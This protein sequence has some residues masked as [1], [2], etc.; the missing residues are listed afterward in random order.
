MKL[1]WTQ[2][3][4]K[5]LEDSYEDK[6][7]KWCSDTLNI[8]IKKVREKAARLGL[9]IKTIWTVDNTKYLKENY[10]KY[11]PNVCASDLGLTWMQIYHKARSLN[12]RLSKEC[13]EQAI[14][15]RVAKADQTKFNN[16]EKAV[17][18]SVNK[19][20]IDSPNIAYLLG[21]IWGD[22]Y[23]HYH[24]KNALPT[25]RIEIA[26]EDSTNLLKLLDKESITYKTYWR[27]R[28]TN[29]RKTVTIYI[30]HLGLRSI[31]E[32]FNFKNKSTLSVGCVIDKIPNNVNQ[33]ILGL[34]DADGC[35]Y[36]KSDSTHGVFN[37]FSSYDY[38]WSGLSD[39]LNDFNIK[40][41]TYQRITNPTKHKGSYLRVSRLDNLSKLIK[42]LYLNPTEF[43]FERKRLKAKMIY[44]R[45][46]THRHPYLCLKWE[47]YNIWLSGVSP[48]NILIKFSDR[49]SL[50]PIYRF[51]KEFKNGIIPSNPKT[52]PL[53]NWGG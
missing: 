29:W 25:I 35:F 15:R 22:G 32:D 18:L 40:C 49:T 46:V 50:S 6:G 12:L 14:T 21:F 2:T 43:C 11:G 24:T 53:I 36:V 13:K 19:I 44:Q 34:S 38:D 45:Y 42:L 9:K 47:I 31:C 30:P 1:V 8:P 17:K 48:K 39:Y 5:I 20:T 28:K 33:F 52:I 27:K 3:M 23:L 16:R 37:L 41:K 4:T 7:A 51:I 26:K 10:Y